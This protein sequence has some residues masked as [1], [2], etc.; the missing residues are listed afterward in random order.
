MFARLSTSFLLAS[1]MLFV[2]CGDD[3]PTTSDGSLEIARTAIG[4]GDIGD[5]PFFMTAEGPAGSGLTFTLRGE[6]LRYE[7]DRLTAEFFVINDGE[8]AVQLPAVLTLVTIDPDSVGVDD[9]D[10]GE[11][12]AG[13]SFGLEFA[14]DDLE[15]SV[16][17][18][19]LAETLA[20]DVDQ[21]VSIAFVA[22]IDVEMDP[23][24]GSIGGTVFADPDQD[25]V[26]S[27]DEVGVG[28]VGIELSGA[29]G[30]LRTSSM[31]GGTYR[32]DGLDAG[33]YTVRILPSRMITP[34]TANAIQVLLSENGE[35]DVGNYLAADF[36][37]RVRNDEPPMGPRL[38]P[39]DVVEVT[40]RYRD[41]SLYAYEIE[42]EDDDDTEVRGPVTAVDAEAGIL[43][44]MG[45]A[46]DVDGLVL[47]GG[48][49]EDI[50]REGP[51]IDLMVRDRARAWLDGSSEAVG[52]TTDTIRVFG[53]ESMKCW[54]G[55]KEKI[56]GP[57]GRIARD[58]DGRIT[59]FGILGLRVVVG[60]DYDDDDDDHDDGDDHD[61][62]D[63][64]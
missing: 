42:R 2:A 51:A 31:R 35:G 5:G 39:G 48:G 45:I 38:Q 46:L 28:G 6:N 50:C 16:G 58:E 37:V 22:R 32:F 26:F 47:R 34:T 9:S 52:D 43:S 60:A 20:F 14:E 30:V 3:S 57:V 29:E 23:V 40:G 64:R 17:E 12:G 61:G 55:D 8:R 15:W 1:L 53:V 49:G 18:E 21:G 56:V 4:D 33:V 62:D 54:S 63:H 27:N 7:D 41:G 59:A 24:G 44:I 11:P 10:N 19:S 36:G 13:A 25:G